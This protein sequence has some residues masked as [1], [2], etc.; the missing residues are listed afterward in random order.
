MPSQRAR[1]NHD[2]LFPGRVSTLAATDPE[3]IEY[4]DNFTFDEVLAHDDLE[5]RTR[6]MVQLAALIVCQA[7]SEYRVMLGAALTIG[8]TSAPSATPPRSPT[9]PGSTPAPSSPSH[10]T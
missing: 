4:F 3:M 6:L 10:S 7:V 5:Q 8:V 9:S 1:R 2:Q